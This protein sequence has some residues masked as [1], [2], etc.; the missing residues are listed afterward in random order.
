MGPT[1][2]LSIEPPC[3]CAGDVAS[4]AAAAAAVAADSQA[5]HVHACP[6]A[7]VHVKHEEGAACC[8]HGAV[9]PFTSHEHPRSS[10]PDGGGGA[11]AQ[12]AG[13]CPAAAG[14]HH[15]EGTAGAAAPAAAG[16]AP[17]PAAAPPVKR[18]GRPPKSCKL[19][20]EAAA[21]P[22]LPQAA[23]GGAAAAAEVGR[24]SPRAPKP[25]WK[26]KEGL[27]L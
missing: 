12:E 4:V 3:A 21:A 2:G 5:G 24:R 9:A 1:G 7:P 20:G 23:T 27:E 8:V 13:D 19:P 17:A 6:P 15:A 26:A 14:A 22:G 25:S 10:S 16:P 11:E 18:R